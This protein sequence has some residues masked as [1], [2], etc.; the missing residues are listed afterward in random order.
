[1]WPSDAL[2]PDGTLGRLTP[3]WR[4]ALLVL[5]FS[6]LI[7]S[8]GTASA[9]TWRDLLQKVLDGQTRDQGG[10]ETVASVDPGSPDDA[11]L[12]P[13][14]ESVDPIAPVDAAL[15]PDGESVDP[16]TPVDA[17]LAPD[18][19]SVDPIAPDDAASASAGQSVKP[20][21]VHLVQSPTRP[22]CATR[23]WYPSARI[24][25]PLNTLTTISSTFFSSSTPRRTTAMSA[26]RASAS[27]GSRE[28]RPCTR[29]TK[30]A[31]WSAKITMPC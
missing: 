24:R 18:G 1:M 5:A 29:S 2:R 27:R 21:Q 20:R 25:R 11:A 4:N 26:R 14:G 9:Q 31:P 7:A 30:G 15:A 19:E 17:A 3:G 10:A 23:S 16:N 6:F 28:A 12:A 13:D 8:A 22:I